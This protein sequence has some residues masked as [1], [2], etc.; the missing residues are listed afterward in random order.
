LRTC[1]NSGIYPGIWKLES[2]AEEQVTS[3]VMENNS[4]FEE[5]YVPI[6]V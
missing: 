4:E 1:D 2:P 6:I 5:N 3:Q